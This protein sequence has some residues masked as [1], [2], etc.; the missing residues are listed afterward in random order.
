[1]KIMA[2]D[3]NVLLRNL[4]IYQ[5]YLR[6]HTEEG[7]FSS[8]LDDLDRIKSMGVNMIHFLPIHPIGEEKKKGELGCPYSIKDYMKVNPEYGTLDD[9]KNLINECHK[10]DIKVMID[11]VFNHTSHDSVL[12]KDHPEW[13]YKNEAGEFANRVGDWWDITDLDFK[14][15]ELWDYLIETL[16][17]WSSLGIDG[18]RCDVAS[19]VPVEFWL[20]AREEVAKVNDQTIWL[21]ESVHPEFLKYI[22]DLGFN[23]WS[24]SEIYQAFDIAYDYDTH[25]QY[26]NYLKGEGSFEK[27]LDAYQA[28]MWNY[29]RNFVKMR[30]L[31]NHDFGRFAPMVDHDV[32]KIHQ[33]TALSFFQYGCTLIYAGQEHLATTKPDLFDIDKVE[34]DQY[35]DISNFISI[36]NELTTGDLFAFGVHSVLKTDVDGVFVAEYKLG[37]EHVLGIFNV[38]LNKGEIKLDIEDGTYT[39]IIYD[40]PLPVK[41]KSIKLSKKPII[42]YL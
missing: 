16:K 41:G 15:L 12:M 38:G 24:E 34:W 33:W 14:N 29:P 9:F 5:V 7:T 2:K 25:K 32:N 18:Y 31:E 17:Y 27:Y 42:L 36:M 3:T 40:E 20:K 8:F 39:N 21:S 22:R 37:D 1:M 35:K 30:N 11:V 26:E 4:F 10:H 23:A 6:Q 13:F 28:Q 19:L